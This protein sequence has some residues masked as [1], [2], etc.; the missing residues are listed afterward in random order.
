MDLTTILGLVVGLAGL[1]IGFL[2]EDGHISMLLKETAFLIVVG[3]TVGATIL[4]FGREELKT[5]PYFI[6]VIFSQKKIDFAETIDRLVDIAD[7]ARREGLLSLETQ[8]DQID[9]AFVRRGMQL[10]ID[11]TDPELTR[12]ML[13]MEIEAYEKRQKVGVDIFNTAG[14]YAPTMGIIGT[15]MGLVQ[16]LS[17]MSEPDKLGGAIAVAFIATLYGVA[18]ANILWL[19][20]ASKIKV[21]TAKDL[22]HMDMILE[23]I[24][25][26]QAGENPRVIREKLL[27]FLPPAEKQSM[28]A[29]ERAE[30]EM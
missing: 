7:K 4:S 3:G 5:V 17:S 28:V 12:N 29:A 14:G 9:N 22:L 24:L 23:G 10:V 21:K 13:E 25:S 20:F 8:M 27:T 11:G 16:V 2:L 1:L 15:V 18:T 26:V 6:K 30:V 19:P